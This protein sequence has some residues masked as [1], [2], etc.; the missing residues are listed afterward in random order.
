MNRRRKLYKWGSIIFVILIFAVSIIYM[1]NLSQ[2]Q[3]EAKLEQELLAEE[4]AEKENETESIESTRYETIGNLP[5][6]DNCSLYDLD[7]R[8]E[9]TVMYLTVRSGNESSGTNHTW[10]EINKNS[11]YYYEE[12]GLERYRAECI[13]QVGNESGPIVG[14]FG[15][16]SKVPNATVT[17]RGQSSSRSAQKNYRIN[18]K[19][20]KGSWEEQT[21]INLNKHVSEGVRYRNKL[22]YELMQE[23][24]G[25]FS[26]RTRF[27][28]LYVKDETEGGS[29]E[30][31][32]YGLY[33]QV[34]QINKRYLKNHGLDNNG[35]LYK[36]NYFEFFR[37]ED[38][39]KLRTDPAYDETEFEKYLEIKGD[40]D[41]S[42]L[43]EMLEDVNDYTLPI[44]EVFAKWFDEEN[45]FSWLSFQI[46][47]GNK[48]TQ[49]RNT[50]LYSP[51][52]VDKWYF[53]SWDNDAAFS[54]V[55]DELLEWS[56]GREW[57][58]GV[59]NY[60][61]NVL[62]RRVLKS[63]YYRQLLEEKIQEYK[64]ILTEELIAEKIAE[65]REV[66]TDYLYSYPDVMYAPLTRAEEELVSSTIPM[67]IEDNY[68][69]YKETYEKPMPFYIGAPANEGGKLTITWE[70]AYDFDEEDISYTV[71][72]A[73][74]LEFSNPI[75]KESGLFYTK[76]E[77]ELP[78]A[79]QYFVRISAK[80]E[81]GYEQTAFDC[82]L[83]DD[84]KV[85]GTKSF[86][87]DESGAVWEDIYEE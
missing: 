17:I 37:Y 14:E 6:E 23:L 53:I 78:Q 66:T 46:L 25:M 20:G 10:S 3:E 81:S 86:W 1:E 49:S 33:T 39:I 61:G 34:E 74:N 2:I 64:A 70:S 26:A 31:E 77:T 67:L 15:Y 68:N 69:R 43:I 38:V 62:I 32:D 84:G 85:Y 16:E 22:C 19:D 13:L 11:A 54:T 21:V 71:E 58:N 4:E 48:D 83:V 18:I 80:N 72:I 47:V 87:I 82:Y 29:G 55:E 50:F 35:Q 63:E 30:F 51:L 65:Y 57:E 8:E 28:H 42:K 41:H 73:D 5:I 79:G 36:I 59:S 27:V 52:N 9:V 40:S 7:E 12:L 45:F 24:P 60:W 44:E 76:I 75:F 56:D